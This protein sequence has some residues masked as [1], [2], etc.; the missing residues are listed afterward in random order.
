M[1]PQAGIAIDAL[2]LRIQMGQPD[3]GRTTRDL[4]ALSDLL[5]RYATLDKPI[6]VTAAGVPRRSGALIS[7]AA[8]RRS[9]RRAR[10]ARMART[11]RLTLTAI[12][13]SGGRPGPPRRRPGG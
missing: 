1:I 10:Q 9:R 3:R 5:D 2:A 11:R 4:M 8:G 13:G 12:P 6:A 7:A